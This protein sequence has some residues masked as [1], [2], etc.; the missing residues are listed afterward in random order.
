MS[1]DAKEK[2]IEYDS[3]FL[4][5]RREAIVIFMIWL[6][7]LAWSVPYCYL[8]GYTDSFDPDSFTTLFGIPTWLL[9]GIAAP[10]FLA[11]LVTTWFCFFFMKDD[12]LGVAADEMEAPTKPEAEDGA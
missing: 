5:S 6:C 9:V 11:D 4:N 3:V 10:W 1:K 2:P 12:D 8:N 7:C